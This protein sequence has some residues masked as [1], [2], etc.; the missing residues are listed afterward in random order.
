ME[1]LISFHGKQEIK[2]FYLN[3]VRNHILN[4]ELIHGVY[5]ENGKGCGIGCTVHSDSHAA[6]E[7]EL[8]IPRLLARLEDGIFE[9][10]ANGRSKQWPEQFLSAIEVGRDLSLVWPHFAVWLMIDKKWGVLQ[11]A[12]SAASKRAIQDVADAYQSI[13]NGKKKEIDWHAL[14]NAAA[15]ATAAANAV[16]VAAVATAVAVAVAVATAAAATA[17]AVAVAAAVAVAGA[18]AAAAAAARFSKRQE[19]HEAQAD[20]LLELLRAA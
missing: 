6:Y 1:R 20:K 2:D 12:K 16:A 14:K 10:M 17:V 7:R 13:V 11:Y 15:A 18:D 5:W 4:D 8:G 9:G 3:R 19:C